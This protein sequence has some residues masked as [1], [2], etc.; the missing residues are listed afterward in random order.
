MTNVTLPTFEI[1]LKPDSDREQLALMVS[2]TID[3]F[4]ENRCA[5]LLN[6]DD[7][8]MAGDI[9]N[10]SVEMMVDWL[11]FRECTTKSSMSVSMPLGKDELAP[12]VIITIEVTV[13]NSED[14]YVALVDTDDSCSDYS[15]DDVSQ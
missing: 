14:D 12:C 15:S 5:D 8:A 10:D 1:N 13:Q 3:E 2:K 6:D 11:S 4:L 7:A 9:I